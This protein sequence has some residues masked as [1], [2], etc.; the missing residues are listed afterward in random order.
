MSDAPVRYTLADKVA[1]LTMDDGK[2][3]AL[4]TAMI[5]ALL[6]ALTQAEAEASA[7]VLTGRADR[8]CAGFDLRVMMSGPEHAIALLNRGAEL[9]LRLFEYPLPLV[10]AST[11]HALAGGVLVVCTGDVRIGAAGDYKYGLNEVAIG[12]P[13][14]MLAMELARARLLPTELTRA[15][16]LAQIYTPTSA[17]AAGYLDQVVAADAV[18]DTA[19][20]EARRLAAL[21]AAAFRAT[22]QRLRGDVARHIRDGFAADVDQV[23]AR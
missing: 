1:T 19:H 23:M 3:N 18:A 21:P 9:L 22:K 17:L 12:L 2:A 15:T 10:I 4:S 11:G 13:V 14:P 20:A 8:F 5:D 7:V 16:L 6:A